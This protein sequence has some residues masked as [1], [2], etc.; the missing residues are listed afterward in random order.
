MVRS[1]SR[2]VLCR[3]PPPPAG[4]GVD[5]RERCGRSFHGACRP[6]PTPSSSSPPDSQGAVAT[7]VERLDGL[8]LAI[9]LAAAQLDALSLDELVTGLEHR[10]AIL[11]GQTRGVTGRLASLEASVEWS[12]RL[13]TDAERRAFRHLS[14]LPI[15][16]RGRGRSGGRTYVAPVVSRLVRR[17]MVGGAQTRPG[18]SVPIRHAGDPASV[19]PGAS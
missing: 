15:L 12:Y 7:I 10:F 11:V 3:C 5:R 9:E 1:V 14:V 18:W 17:S 16:H 19:W 6:G 2:W 8:P 13:L 4:P